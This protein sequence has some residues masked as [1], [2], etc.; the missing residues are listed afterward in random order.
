MVSWETLGFQDSLAA[1]FIREGDPFFR[2]KLVK[3]GSGAYYWRGQSF[4]AGFSRK[5]ICF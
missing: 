5:L 2:A 1:N 4:I 3:F